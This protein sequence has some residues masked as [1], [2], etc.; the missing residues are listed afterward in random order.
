[1]N[2]YYGGPEIVALRRGE[3][4]DQVKRDV[5]EAIFS[6][7]YAISYLNYASDGLGQLQD[8]V[9]RDMATVLME[10]LSD[11]AEQAKQLTAGIL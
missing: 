8:N 7:G 9:E 10:Q 2:V 6:I 5:D 1:M 3:A 11:I 4:Y